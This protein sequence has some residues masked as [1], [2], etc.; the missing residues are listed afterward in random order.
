MVCWENQ[1]RY[2]VEEY[3]GGDLGGMKILEIGSRFGR[4][5][6]LFGLLGVTRVVGV[7]IIEE[8]VDAANREALKWGVETELHSRN[9]LDL[10]VF[11]NETFG[12]AFTKTRICPC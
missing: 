10:W 12:L 9:M 3:L 11:P 4:M 7:D 2:A 6:S 5:A 1:V 8:Y